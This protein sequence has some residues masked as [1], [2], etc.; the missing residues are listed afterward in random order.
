[1]RRRNNNSYIRY[2]IYFFTIYQRFIFCVL[3]CKTPFDFMEYKPAATQ[4]PQAIQAPRKGVADRH[5]VAQSP[6]GVVTMRIGSVSVRC[7]GHLSAISI[8]R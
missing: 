1:M 8:R 4:R 7:T 3:H 2:K 5:P 6:T